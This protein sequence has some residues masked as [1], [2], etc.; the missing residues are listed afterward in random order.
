MNQRLIPKQIRFCHEYLVDGDASKA[1]VRA[2]YSPKGTSSVACRVLRLPYVKAYLDELLAELREKYKATAEKVIQEL[3]IVAYSDISAFIKPGNEE[4][5]I[6]QL[7]PE[8]RRSASAINIS[9]TKSKNGYHTH[10]YIKLHDKN[11]ALRQLARHLGIQDKADPKKDLFVRVIRVE[12]VPP[13]TGPVILRETGT[14]A[15]ISPAEYERTIGP[16]PDKYTYHNDDRPAKEE[17][18]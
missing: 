3:A 16:L 9:R 17:P 6:S 13:P 12:A 8:V 7:P 10:V 18:L 5:D 4:A 15:I 11:D 2:G 1:L 14:K